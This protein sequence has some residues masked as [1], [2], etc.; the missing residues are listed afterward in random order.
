MSGLLETLTA[1][2]QLE[3]GGAQVLQAVDAG[4]DLVGKLLPP[5]GTAVNVAESILSILN[6]TQSA[7]SPTTTDLQ[8]QIA[9]FESLVEQQ[10]GNLQATVAGGQVKQNSEDLET[11]LTGP[12][13]SLT[14]V[15]E[16]PKLAKAP[17]LPLADA[18][19]AA[20]YQT[21]ARSA[22]LTLLG[23]GPAAQAPDARPTA[24][25]WL[26]AGDLPLFQPTNAWTYNGTTNMFNQPVVVSL[27]SAGYLPNDMNPYTGVATQLPTF[28]LTDLHFTNDFSPT[29]VENVPANNAFNPTWVLQQS[30]AAVYY[31][32]LICGAVLS[33]FPNDGSTI[34]DFVGENNFAGNLLWYHDQIRAGIVNIAPPFPWDLVPIDSNGNIPATASGGTSSWS[35]P[36]AFAS[37]TSGSVQPFF[38]S[39][40][41]TNTDVPDYVRPFGALCSYTGFVAGFGGSQPS[42]DSYPDY[43]YPTPGQ[44]AF[45]PGMQTQESNESLP[46][47]AG[48]DWYVAFYSKYLVACL[49]RVKLVYLGMGLA[50]LWSTINSLYVMC[51][52][53]A[54]PSPCFGDWSLRA[55]F[56]LLGSANASTFPLPTTN[57]PVI[58]ETKLSVR[59]FLTFMNGA[60]PT[61]ATASTSLRAVLQA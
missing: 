10:L 45:T 18:Q 61:P 54:Q 14:I 38:G 26:P 19:Q 47:N 11:L 58:G 25:W 53:A 17:G 29:P 40:S 43:V 7:A 60:A 39:T 12:N 22:L 13:G 44:P 37:S 21:Y 51:G 50:S 23:G 28:D 8:N 9:A 52:Q 3:T 30:M 2:M 48:T 46:A 33:G 5:L 24:Y 32:L 36:S 31:Y 27:G 55:V 56:K 41:V 59:A 35:V 42:V 49:Y 57:D 15:G 1:N 6:P 34:P 20:D 4:I 16:L